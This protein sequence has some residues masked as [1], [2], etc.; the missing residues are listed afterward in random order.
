MDTI[1]IITIVGLSTI[2]GVFLADAKFNNSKLTSYV[3]N[4]LF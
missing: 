1:Y 4:K 3:A 2:C